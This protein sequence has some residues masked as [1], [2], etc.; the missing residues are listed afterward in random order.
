MVRIS[1]GLSKR[2]WYTR[3]DSAHQ[4]LCSELAPVRSLD[5]RTL[6]ESRLDKLANKNTPFGVIVFSWYSDIAS[7]LPAHLT[8]FT[9]M[10][11][12]YVGMLH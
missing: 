11:L 9:L 1:F 3:R 10:G 8:H 4:Q 7:C 2:T 12:L 5:D 6:L